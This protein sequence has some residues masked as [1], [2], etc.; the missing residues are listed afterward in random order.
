MV[1]AAGEPI[2]FGDRDRVKLAPPGRGQH[3]VEA[4]PLR[5]GA[6]DAVVHVS[7]DN[8]QAAGLCAGLDQAIDSD[9]DGITD[10]FDN[11]PS[12]PNQGQEDTDM[13]GVGDACNDSEDMD[14]DDWADNLDNCPDIVNDQT[15]SDGDG[16]GDACDPFPNDPNNELAQCEMDLA[17]ALEELD[18]CQN[19]PPP[20]MPDPECS[21]GIDNDGDGAIDLEDRQCRS[22][23]QVSEKHPNR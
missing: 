18:M 19:P 6:A 12:V 14:D 22:A 10:G 21:D 20:P 9:G 16:L 15:D 17:D 13:N 11:C 7:I 1:N 2:K 8:L 4:L 3:A 5:L 23:D